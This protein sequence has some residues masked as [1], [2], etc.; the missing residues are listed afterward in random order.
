MPARYFLDRVALAWILALIPS[1]AV[2]L[3][4][5]DSH[6][7]QIGRFHLVGYWI[8]SM[9]SLYEAWRVANF[10]ERSNFYVDHEWRRR[11]V[12]MLGLVGALV[13]SS[14]FFPILIEGYRKPSGV[15][16]FLFIV[17]GFIAGAKGFVATREHS[18]AA[19]QDED[20]KQA[21]RIQKGCLRVF[22]G[23]V[24]L[25]G[26]VAF[27]DAMRA[28]YVQIWDDWWLLT[29]VILM[30]IALVGAFIIYPWLLVRALQSQFKAKV[31]VPV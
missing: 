16:T 22:A 29:A 18:I 4:A 30:A 12:A 17:L 1:S 8:L 3:L 25:L 14:V 23:I 15:V 28:L 26:V 6:A 9:L 10:G 20:L 2:C 11:P 21:R 7:P 31:I 5:H 24:T 27:S 19:C 13:F